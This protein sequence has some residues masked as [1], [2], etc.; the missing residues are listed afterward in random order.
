MIKLNKANL[1]TCLRVLCS[2]VLLFCSPFS[3]TF[4]IFYLVAGLSDV[5]DGP[6]A[7]KEN[8]ASEFGAIF[9]SA[10][11]FVF[12]IICLIKLL[13]GLMIPLWMLIWIVG[14]AVIKIMSFVIC[15]LRQN[16]PAMAHTL[17]NKITGMLLFLLP[18]S[19]EQI[20]LRYSGSVVCIF[21]TIAAI[22]ELY[23]CFDL[24]QNKPNDSVK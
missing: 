10:A 19:I 12:V 6:I 1:L 2:L 9:D 17:L 23:S 4:C 16:K 3:S 11:D 14:I 20:D 15:S 7:R 8:T 24:F 18:L 22:Q 5:L 21:A 13:P